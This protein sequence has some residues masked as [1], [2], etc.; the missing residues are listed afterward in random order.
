M[1]RGGGKSKGGSYEREISVKLSLWLSNGE[2]DDWVWRTA[3]S[4]GRQTV[5]RKKG[6]NRSNQSGDI[7]AI[8]E[9]AQYFFSMYSVECKYYKSLGLDNLVAGQE[10]GWHLLKFW[11][12]AYRDAMSANKRPILIAKQNR[13]PSIVV[14][15]S[16]TFTRLGGHGMLWSKFP[17]FSLYITDLETFLKTITPPKKDE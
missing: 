14:V 5:G 17:T 1:R 8:S 16:L 3:M 15:D 6:K 13:L 9:G 2:H 11:E 7:S 4:G 10:K 12:Q